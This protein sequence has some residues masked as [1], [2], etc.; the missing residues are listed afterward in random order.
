[1]IVMASIK[2]KNY[3]TRGINTMVIIVMKK[4]DKDMNEE[5]DIK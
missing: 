5:V 4:Y 2:Y 1:M 3:F